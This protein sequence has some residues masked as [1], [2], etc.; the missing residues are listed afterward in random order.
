MSL[1]CQEIGKFSISKA[2]YKFFVSCNVTRK[3]GKVCR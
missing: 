3:I 1:M 2:F